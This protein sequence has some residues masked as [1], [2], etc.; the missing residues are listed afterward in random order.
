MTT[1]AVTAYALKEL[2]SSSALILGVNT[3]IPPQATQDGQIQHDLIAQDLEFVSAIRALKKSGKR[4]V[5]LSSETLDLNSV[6]SNIGFSPTDFR[7]D[8]IKETATP[9]TAAQFLTAVETWGFDRKN[10]VDVAYLDG[11]P[12]NLAAVYDGKRNLAT[13]F[14]LNEKEGVIPEV[15]DANTDYVLP[16]VNNAVGEGQYRS[17]A[18][19]VIMA[20]INHAKELKQAA[21]RRR[22]PAPKA[23]LD[24]KQ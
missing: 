5:I 3:L 14:L 18:A 19:V 23:I 2:L 4:I 7:A 17:Q 20:A 11:S 1:Q 24:L 10:G 8:D 21:T 12:Q 13:Q 6:L 22:A 16:A 15:S 9:V